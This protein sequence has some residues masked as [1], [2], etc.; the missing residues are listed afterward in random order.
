MAGAPEA[1]RPMFLYAL[2]LIRLKWRS[3][4]FHSSAVANDSNASA[5]RSLPRRRSFSQPLRGFSSEA[6]EVGGFHHDA[7]Q[8]LRPGVAKKSCK[9]PGKRPRARGQLL[10]AA[11]EVIAQGDDYADGIVF[12]VRSVAK[13]ARK[14]FALGR[15]AAQRESLLFELI[16]D[17]QNALACR[18]GVRPQDYA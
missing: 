4:C 3:R 16:H 18:G 17:Q 9:P 15:R 6:G 1:P 8:V 13:G 10:G 7:P 11:E 14:R 12:R 2:W 5:P